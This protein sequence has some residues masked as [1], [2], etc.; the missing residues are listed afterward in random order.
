MRCVYLKPELMNLS[1]GARISFARQIRRMTQDELADKLG[2]TGEFKRR[3][4]TRYERGDRV[5]KEERLNEIACILN[6]NAKCLKEFDYKNEEDMIYMFLWLEEMY[7]IINIDLGI[8]EYFPNRRD[9]KLSIFINEWQLM[10][11]KRNNREIT[12]DEYI[13]CK[14]QYEF[15]GS[16]GDEKN[17]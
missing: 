12:Y 9:R 4:V 11:N 5:P 3:G 10:R 2:F 8:S 1:Q 15:I 17:S 14:L 6:V 7:P 16:D 13:E